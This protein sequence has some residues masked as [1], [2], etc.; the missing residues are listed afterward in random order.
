LKI[1][2]VRGV[3][4]FCAADLESPRNSLENFPSA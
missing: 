4:K 2:R 3:T 1:L